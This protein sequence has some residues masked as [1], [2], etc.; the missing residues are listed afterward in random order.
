M[1][2]PSAS[3][4]GA[5]ALLQEPLMTHQTPPRAEGLYDP[6]YEHDACGVALVARLDNRP[7]HQVVD[8]ALT[9]LENLEHRGAAR[10]DKHT[11]GSA[12]VLVQKPHRFLCSVV[13]FARAQ[14]CPYGAGESLL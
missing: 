8:Q 13:D 2:Y 11:G 9:A 5:P 3:A 1:L 12:G 7:T 10:A 6:R 4:S 14:P